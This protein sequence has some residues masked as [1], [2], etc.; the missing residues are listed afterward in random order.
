MPNNDSTVVNN[1][2]TPHL[3]VDGRY[4]CHFTETQ[5]HGNLLP[6]VALEHAPNIK[7][8]EREINLY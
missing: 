2:L 5:K 3:V 1:L 7:K 4:G 8:K 6:R